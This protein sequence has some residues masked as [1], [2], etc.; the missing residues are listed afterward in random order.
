[1]RRQTIEKIDIDEDVDCLSPGNDGACPHSDPVAREAWFRMVNQKFPGR[2]RFDKWK[3]SVSTD[4]H[5][6]EQSVC[7]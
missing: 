1:M 3:Q 5:S 6:D 4:T 7:I 2:Y